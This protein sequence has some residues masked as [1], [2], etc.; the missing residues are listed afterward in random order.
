MSVALCSLEA[1]RRYKLTGFDIHAANYIRR[2]LAPDNVLNVLAKLSSYSSLCACKKKDKPEIPTL[3]SAP[4]VEEFDTEFLEDKLTA[5]Q[6]KLNADQEMYDKIIKK[7]LQVLDENA[8]NILRSEEFEMIPLKMMHFILKR[9]S[10][11]I[12][13]EL[14]FYMPW[15]VGGECSASCR[16]NHLP[17]PTSNFN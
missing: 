1:G 11:C 15:I 13:S 3:P 9:D 6:N 4:A 2:N 8:N 16:N 17:P 12:D 14:A 10:L 5:E 7:C